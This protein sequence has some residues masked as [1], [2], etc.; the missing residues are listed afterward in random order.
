[1]QQ[2]L[3]TPRAG[4]R[5]RRRSSV[6]RRPGFRGVASPPCGGEATSDAAPFRVT[7][8]TNAGLEDGGLAHRAVPRT[9][10]LDRLLGKALV[11]DL[12]V[13]WRL[14][15]LDVADLGHQLG[16]EVDALRNEAGV[17]VPDAALHQ[18][19]KPVLHDL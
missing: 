12:V 11:D 3:A 19:V 5:H 14:A 8:A 15:L 4:S 10:L 9:K 13:G 7:F 6:S 16:G 2:E 18:E 1:P 17:G